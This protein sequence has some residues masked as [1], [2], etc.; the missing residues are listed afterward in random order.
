MRLIA[1][2]A[3]PGAQ[4]SAMTRF[5]GSALTRFGLSATPAS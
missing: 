4:I 3:H 1:E 2:T 5:D